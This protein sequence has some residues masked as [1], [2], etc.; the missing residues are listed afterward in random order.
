MSW[1]NFISSFD[2]FLASTPPVVWVAIATSLVYVFLAAKENPWCWPFGII[3][4]GIYVWY[5]YELK[6]YNDVGLSVYYCLVGAYGW[7]AWLSGK[8]KK[9]G[10]AVLH[11]GNALTLTAAIL[12]GAAASAL[13]GWLSDTYTDSEQPYFDGTLTAFSLVA[14]WMTARKILENWIFWIVVD[15]A[16]IVLYFRSDAHATALL[17]LIF[18]IIAVYGFLKWRKKLRQS[19]A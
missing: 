18:T 14:T 19:A 12:A 13:L 9:R 1:E 6:L 11:R 2:E 17:N 10:G 3:S 7:Y 15:A 5:N 8:T 4:S 16:Y